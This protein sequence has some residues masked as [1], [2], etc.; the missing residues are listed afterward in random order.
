MKY[1]I[2]HQI[3]KLFQKTKKA[4]SRILCWSFWKMFFI[5]LKEFPIKLSLFC[6]HAGIYSLSHIWQMTVDA[7]AVTAKM[8]APCILTIHHDTSDFE[9]KSIKQ[10]TIWEPLPGRTSLPNAVLRQLRSLTGTASGEKMHITSP[11][12]TPFKPIARKR[13]MVTYEWRGAGGAEGAEWNHG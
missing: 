12:A 1:I 10:E 6:A 7:A 3:N 9:G 2:T 5:H 8:L 13:C 4:C 11:P